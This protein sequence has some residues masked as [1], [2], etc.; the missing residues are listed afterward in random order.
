MNEKF[1]HLLNFN[2]KESFGFSSSGSLVGVIWCFWVCLA[3]SGLGLPSVSRA[4]NGVFSW[5]DES[6]VLHFSSKKGDPKAQQAKLPAINRGEVQLVKR[7]LLSC[8]NHGGINCQAGADEDGSVI[9]YDGFRDSAPIYRFSCNAPKLEVADISDID[10]NGH[11]TVT[12]RN[13]KS[14]VAES[15]IVK[16]LSESGAPVVLNGPNRIDGYGVGE[17]VFN[18]QDADIPRGPVNLAQLQLECGNC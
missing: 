7:K 2:L 17:F 3:S 1:F 12:V 5:E 15:P 4:E 6:G 18:A 9:C 10:M 14:I 8:S 16:F 11:F 13:S